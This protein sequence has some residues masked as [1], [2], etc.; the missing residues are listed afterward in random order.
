MFCK[1]F[2]YFWSMIEVGN[3]NKLEILRSTS[4]GLFLGDGEGTEILLPTK[5]APEAFSIGDELTVFCYLDHEERPVATTIKP[6]IRRNTFGY[7]KVEDVNDYGAF[8]DW[9]LEKQLMVPFREQAVRMQVGK[10]YVVFCYLDTETFR[11]VA[12]SRLHKFLDDNEVALAP[13]EEVDLLITRKTDLGWEAII[14]DRH[15]GLIFLDDVYASIKTGDRTKG[16]V[17]KVRNDN[18][19]DLAL[20]PLGHKQ[21]DR[22]AEKVYQK[23]SEAGGSLPFHDRSAPEAIKQHFQMSKKSFK[24]AIGVLYRERKITITDKG[25]TI[26]NSA[27]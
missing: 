12:S 25:I 26:S 20:Q 27:I 17:K 19:V 18:K 11:L 24:K 16:F 3:Y 9:G 10:S 6:K 23:L 21:L 5:Y 1:G 15:I 14:N 4:V 2:F 7:L 8:L 13:N 22:N